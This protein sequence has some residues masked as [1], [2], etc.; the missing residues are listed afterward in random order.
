MD[1]LAIIMISHNPDHAFAVATA[2]ALLHH[3][4]LQVGRPVDVVTAENLALAYG[5]EIEILNGTAADGAA[6]TACVPLL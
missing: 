3:E 1:G 6:V 5:A 4:T 2:A